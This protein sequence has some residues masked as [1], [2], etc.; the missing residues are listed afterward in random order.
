MERGSAVSLRTA[1]SPGLY[2]IPAIAISS[3]R[4]GFS[5][6]QPV[7]MRTFPPDD[8]SSHASTIDR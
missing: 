5:T 6:G 2:R 7:E 8:G 4:T 3:A 1:D